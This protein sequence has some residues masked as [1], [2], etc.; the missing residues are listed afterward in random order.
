[1]KIKKIYAD[2]NGSLT[3]Q[4]IFIKNT[5]LKIFLIRSFKIA[6]LRR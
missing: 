2:E 4:V 6:K 3:R 5:K 1:M